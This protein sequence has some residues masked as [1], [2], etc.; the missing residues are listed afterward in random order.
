MMNEISV[1]DRKLEVM[2][3]FE[4]LGSLITNNGTQ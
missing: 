1:N 4:Y 2:A 3:S